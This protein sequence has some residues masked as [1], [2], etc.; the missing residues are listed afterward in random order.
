MW[1][2]KSYVTNSGLLV[3]EWYRSVDR[4]VWLDFKTLLIFLD[5]QPP[6][7][8]T[9][10]YVGTLKNECEKLFEIRFDH[11]N[12]EYR[13]IG[14]YSGK[15]EFTILFFATERDSKFEPPTACE[16]AQRHRDEIEKDEEKSREFW[17]EKRD[18]EGDKGK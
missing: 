3:Q 1:T 17:F 6:S 5:G 11:G 16:I 8:W 13:P 18:S 12:V 9:R 4:L 7:S 14:F 2:W 15:K 10:P